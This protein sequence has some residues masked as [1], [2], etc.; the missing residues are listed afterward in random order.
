MPN[1][2]ANGRLRFLI[3]RLRR[4]YVTWNGLHRSQLGRL[5]GAGDA[6]N[7]MV[8]IF[9]APCDEQVILQG[10]DPARSL[11]RRMSAGRC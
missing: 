3:E 11:L 4:L 1:A 2:F 10:T 8:A 7:L 5:A 6:G 9:Q